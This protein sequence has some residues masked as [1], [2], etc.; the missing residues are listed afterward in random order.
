MK[1]SDAEKSELSIF[2][3]E[4]LQSK[5]LLK[6]GQ[7]ALV[8]LEIVEVCPVGLICKELEVAVSPI[9]SLGLSGR[10]L[11]LLKKDGIETVEQLCS[12]DFDSL[13]GIEKFGRKAFSEC[14]DKLLELGFKLGLK[15]KAPGSQWTPP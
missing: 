1:I 2:I 14:R 9:E 13:V 11:K 5:N 7:R 4:W 12:K 10:T 3:N 15:W 8:S 6:A